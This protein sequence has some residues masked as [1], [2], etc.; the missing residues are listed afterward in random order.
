M[1]DAIR[2]IVIVFESTLNLDPAGC[3]LIHHTL[4]GLAGLKFTGRCSIL[5]QNECLSNLTEEHNGLDTVELMPLKVS[6]GIT[7]HFSSIK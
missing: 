4:Y 7:N 6:F 5:L 2:E 3:I 1:S